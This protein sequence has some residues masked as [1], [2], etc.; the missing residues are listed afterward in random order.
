MR[1]F[2]SHHRSFGYVS[3][4]CFP[5]NVQPWSHCWL[6]WDS[7]TTIGEIEIIKRRK[8]IN[9]LRWQFQYK[10]KDT[11]NSTISAFSV[12]LTQRSRSKKKPGYCHV[13]MEAH[14]IVSFLVVSIVL[15]LLRKHEKEVQLF[16]ISRISRQTR[17]SSS[18][19]TTEKRTFFFLS[20][21]FYEQSN[22]IYWNI[23]HYIMF[24]R[25][26]IFFLLLWNSIWL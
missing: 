2:F 4:W 13:K 1:R 21:S 12:I 15:Q 19:Q 16:L 3:L 9:Y 18:P 25:I 22:S 8:I 26:D 10:T 5:T 7:W 6:Q 14:S 24:V 17:D 11:T 20:I 23:V